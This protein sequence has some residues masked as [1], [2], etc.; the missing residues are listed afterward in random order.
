MY[1]HVPT[2]FK[3][4]RC[5]SFT[6]KERRNLKLKTKLVIFQYSQSIKT[7]MCR[8]SHP[9]VFLR[10]GVLKIC[11]TFTELP[12]R[13][14]ISIKLLCNFIEIT[15]RHGC[16]PVNFLHIFSTLFLGTPLSGCF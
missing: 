1:K 15:L 2:L 16:S 12:S 14:V 8:S 10:K 13:S 9:E 3:E 5:D 4:E 7:T 11:S 6:Q